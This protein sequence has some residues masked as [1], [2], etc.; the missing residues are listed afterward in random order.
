MDFDESK[1][2]IYD[3]PVIVR[4]FIAEVLGTFVQI[5]L[6]LCSL[7]VV[8]ILP[9]YAT[10]IYTESG[11]EYCKSLPKNDTSCLGRR[12]ST[13]VYNIDLVG[14]KIIMIAF[15]WASGTFA[16]LVLS[17]PISGGYHNPGI[18]IAMATLSRL[19]WKSLLHLLPAQYLA[20]ILSAGST[21]LMFYEYMPTPE[22]KEFYIGYAMIPSP[23]KEINGL[24]MSFIDSFISCFLYSLVLF[25][26]LDTKGNPMGRHFQP[27]MCS[28]FLFSLIFFHVI[29][30]NGVPFNPARDLGTRLYA[31]FIVGFEK[32]FGQ[33]SYLFW[34]SQQLS[35]VLGFICGAWIYVTFFGLP[36]TTLV[37]GDEPNKKVSDY[38]KIKTTVNQK[39]DKT[40][41]SP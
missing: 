31:A 25:A 22:L 41:K 27:I 40:I 37:L 14:L 8:N 20:V 9:S 6:G 19:S 5:L 39:S 12:Q 1:P 24:T 28:F 32:A 16:G 15:T 33:F 23:H 13:I 4:E 35:T 10:R 2:F 36:E 7:F 21:H 38:H 11:Y 26:T 29:N 18:S 3:M 34:L 17:L 30:K